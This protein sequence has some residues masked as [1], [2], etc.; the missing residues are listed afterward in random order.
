MELTISKLELSKLLHITLAIAEKKSSMP[1]F[2]NLLL[3]AR[4]KSF[5]VTASDLEITAIAT[6]NAR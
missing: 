3:R 6:C 5:E 4:D 1:I 2:G